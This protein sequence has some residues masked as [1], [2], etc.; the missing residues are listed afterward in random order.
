MIE[1]TILL[2]KL[3]TKLKKPCEECQCICH[4]VDESIDQTVR[5]CRCLEK[6]IQKLE[7]MKR[8]LEESQKRKCPEECPCPCDTHVEVSEFPIATTSVKS[9]QS[10]T[11]SLGAIEEED[12]DEAEEVV[13]NEARHTSVSEMRKFIDEDR[14][15]ISSRNPSMKYTEE[16]T[17]DG[18]YRKIS[19]V[20][21]LNK[22]K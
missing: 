10:K 9:Q 13:E 4:P 11:K 15:S 18:F 5:Q 19:N 12:A 20:L 14:E 8:A 6:R 21:R 17:S 22:K 16:R 2:T 7:E 1:F 3:D